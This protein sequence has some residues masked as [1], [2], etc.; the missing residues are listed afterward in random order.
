MK[1]KLFTTLM[2]SLCALSIFAGDL[3]GYWRSIDQTRNMEVLYTSRGIKARQSDRPGAEWINYDRFDDNRYRDARGN[4]LSFSGNSLEWCTADRRQVINYSRNSNNTNYNSGSYNSGSRPSDWSGGNDPRSNYGRNDNADRGWNDRER[5]DRDW[6]KRDRDSWNNYYK[7]YEGKWH[8][9]TTGEKII[10]DLTRNSL[11]IK[12]KGERWFDVVE[13]NR[14]LFVDKRGNE[15]SFRDDQIVFH[16][17]DGDL[18]MRFYGDARCDHHDDYRSE[19]W[20]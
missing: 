11:R 12:F 14:G 9:H 15:F 18:S 10:V 19:Y 8:N 7:S 4:Y 20:R 17:T 1:T 16:S 6:N 5:S 13:R 3:E 2:F